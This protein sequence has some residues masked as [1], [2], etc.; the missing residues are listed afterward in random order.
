MAIEILNK[1]KSADAREVLIEA[2]FTPIL[3]KSIYP[4]REFFEKDGVQY[5]FDFPIWNKS[6]VRIKQDNTNISNK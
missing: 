5:S 6:R 4:C 3:N 1:N 2:G